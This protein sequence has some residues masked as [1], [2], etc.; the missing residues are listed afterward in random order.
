MHI[1][2]DRLLIRPISAEDWPA[3]RDIWVALAASPF[4]QYD[5]PHNTDPEDV[6]ARIA[7]WAAATA[8]STEH[9]FFVV[10]LNGT[11]IGYVAFNARENGHEI[12]YS[13]HPAHHGRGYAKASLSALLTHLRERGFIR[14]SAGTALNNTPSVKLLTSL[15]FRLAGTEQVSFYKDADG[16]DIVFEGGIYELET[17]LDISHLEAW[18]FGSTEALANALLRLVLEGKKRATSSAFP[19]YALSGEELPQVGEMS[20][21]TWWDGTPGCVIRTTKVEIIPYNQI[22][23]DLAQLEGED[24]DLASWQ[25][26]HRAFFE[27]ESTKLG[28]VFTGDMP[29]VVEEF[30]VVEVL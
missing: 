1:R 20:V 9:M 6:R 13:F 4:V 16:Q 19:G 28:Y 25:R 12:G 3:V 23:F 18:H 27:A 11:V 24:D 21:I 2:T 8:D 26:N 7:R 30:E 15:G 22:T 5:K 17:S 14:F 10:C 29:V